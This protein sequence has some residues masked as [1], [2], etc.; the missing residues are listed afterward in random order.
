MAE[1][2]TLPE[3]GENVESGIVAKILISEGDAVSKDQPVLELETDK[4]VLE[5]PSGVEGTVSKIHVSEGAEVTVGDKVFEVSANGQVTEAKEAPRETPK[6][7]PEQ[8]AEPEEAPAKQEAEAPKEEAPKEQEPP[9]KAAQEEAPEE[10]APR[11]RKPEPEQ[12]EQVPEKAQQAAPPEGKAAPRM[13]RHDGSAVPAAP[14]VR[15]FAREIGVDI[16]EVKGTGPGGRISIADI[17]DFSRS[18]NT[19]SRTG[20]IPASQQTV[21]APP[22]PDFARWGEVEYQ[23]MSSVRRRTAESM[24]GAWTTIPQVTQFDKADVTE[25][26]RLRKQFAKKVEQSGGKLT[27][28]AILMKVLAA[29][30]KKYPQFNASIDMAEQEIILKKYYHIGVAVDTDRGLLVPVVR[31]VDQKNLT[32]LSVELTEMAE[33]ARDRKTGLEEMQGGT[34]TISNLGGIGGTGFS[35]IVYA[36]QVAIIG[37]SR[38]SMEQVHVNGQFEPRLMLPLSLTYDHRLIDG[39]DGARFLRWVCEAL[40]QPFLLFVEG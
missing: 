31:D 38:A 9:P 19:Q 18:L 1:A 28:T 7:A 17:K 26:E 30:L 35:P 6:A 27:V 22:L 12:A 37:V 23:A 16:H 8:K 40:E 2:F 3:L 34:F 21:A 36:P 13:E 29:A 4:A 24:T 39:A 20:G 33:R 14:S 25:L 15:A 5:V 11:R 32:E 10:E